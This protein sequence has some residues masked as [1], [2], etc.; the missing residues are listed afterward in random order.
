MIKMPFLKLRKKRPKGTGNLFWKKEDIEIQKQS[1]K[2]LRKI[3][4]QNKPILKRLQ[5]AHDQRQLNLEL[6][7]KHSRHSALKKLIERQTKKPFEKLLITDH[8]NLISKLERK[9][10]RLSKQKDDYHE[11]A[12]LIMDQ[13]EL[14]KNSLSWKQKIARDKRQKRKK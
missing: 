11:Q 5:D 13:L 4:E 9:L 8:K 14:L 7:S 3:E 2:A 12:R 10:S 1:S 6:T